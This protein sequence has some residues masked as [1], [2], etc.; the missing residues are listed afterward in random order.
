MAWAVETPVVMISGFTKK[1]NEFQTPYRVIN[2]NVCNG[3]WNDTSIKF[4]P[5]NWAWCPR[6]KDFECSKQIS[7]E[8]VLEQVRRLT[9][10][11]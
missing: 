9:Y 2:E 8:M 10:I 11:Q 3:C 5:A 4:D 6:Q 7:A 1:Y